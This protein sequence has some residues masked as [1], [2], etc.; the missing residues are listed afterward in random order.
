MIEALVQE[1]W[2]VPDQVGRLRSLRDQRDHVGIHPLVMVG[3]LDLP[4]PH[5]S[6]RT[7]GVEELTRWVADHA[8]LPFYRID[9]MEIDVDAVTRLVSQAYARRYRILP[10]EIRAHEVVIATSE[11]FALTW[12]KDLGQ[13]LRKEIKVVVASPLDVNRYLMELYGVSRSVQRATDLKIRGDADKI[14]N[15]EQL[16]E[17][18]RSSN[19]TAD[20]QH[21]VFIVDWLLQYAFDQ[22]ASDIHLEP[23]RER[24]NVRFRID[25]QLSTVYQMPTPVMGAVTARI[26]V[27]GRM[28][29]AE[30]RRPQDGR[31]KTRS[32]EGRE[33][34]LRLSIMPTAFGEKCVMRIFDPDLVSVGFEELGFSSREFEIWR[35][36]V[37]RPHGIV[38][39][40]GPTGS[41]KTTTLYATLRHLARPEVNVCTVE[42][43][44]E[45]V[46]P[47]INQMQVQPALGVNFASGVRTLLRQDPDI[48]MIGEIRDLE[49][50][51]M[52]IQAAMTGHL[53]LSTLHTND[54]PS[55]VTRLQDLGVPHYLLR[56][57][58]TGIVAQRL[59]RTLCADCRQKGAVDAAAWE[60]LV[61]RWKLP[62]PKQVNAPLGCDNCRNTGYRGRTAIYEMLELDQPL[63]ELIE[64]ETSAARLAAA[65]CQRG[66]RPLRVAAALKVAAGLTTIEEAGRVVPPEM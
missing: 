25:G 59:L 20:D 65:A 60:A 42:D 41:G 44:I 23:R 19:L 43:P 36:M 46:F 63:L 61:G 53:V 58:L 12:V 57:T 10:V 15:F 29:V 47:E 26:K 30:K 66:M 14:L 51:H 32:P 6:A 9:P 48:I 34:E 56:G 49:T 17:L 62:V 45:M 64:A 11:P 24:S 54:S 8:G 21:I 1:G 16:L 22:R 18:G 38:L 37:E 4:H 27:L 28:D 50:A 52:A 39:V 33:V 40:T 3:T 13:I 2:V 31:I 55:A 5:D 7:L 35:R